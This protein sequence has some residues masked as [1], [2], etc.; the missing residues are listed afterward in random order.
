MQT[1]IEYRLHI[2]SLYLLNYKFCDYVS[3]VIISITT[4]KY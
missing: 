3:I 2:Y 1:E 4:D